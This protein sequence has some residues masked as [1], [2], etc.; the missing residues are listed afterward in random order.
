MAES[1]GQ[2]I[3]FALLGLNRAGTILYVTLVV[4]GGLAFVG[5]TVWLPGLRFTDADER[6]FRAARH[7]DLPGIERSL[8]DGATVSA[9]APID[10]KTALFRAAVFGQAGAVRLLLERGADPGARGND[11]QLPIEVVQ[12]AR[13]EE[14]DPAAGRALDAVADLLRIA[15][16]KP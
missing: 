13:A 5:Y 11:G 4:L 9:A 12:A 1:R 10:G 6:L 15:A 8:A 3:L 7:G 2:S 14:T 16:A